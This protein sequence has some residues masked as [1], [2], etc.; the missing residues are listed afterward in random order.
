MNEKMLNKEINVIRKRLESNLVPLLIFFGSIFLLITFSGTRLFFSDEGIILD[1]FYN[2]IQG[3]LALKMAKIDTARGVLITVGNNLFG[4]FS[5]SLLILSLPVFY[6]LRLI[7]SV[8]GAHLFILQIWAFCGGMIVY[9]IAWD[10]KFKHTLLD[11]IIA[12]FLLV[13][14]NLIYFKPI[15]FPKWGE[16]LSIELTNIFIMSFI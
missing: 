5:Y 12:Y 13:Y 11:G 2:L 16:L 3:S 8:Y 15:Y 4:V 10:R 7:E 9:L 6:F 1:Q 14:S